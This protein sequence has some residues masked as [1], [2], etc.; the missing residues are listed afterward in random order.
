MKS[1]R[2]VVAVCLLFYQKLVY[3]NVLCWMTCPDSLTTLL[4]AS[5]ANQFFEEMIN[6]EQFFT[7]TCE[8]KEI[9]SLDK[10]VSLPIHTCTRA[11]NFGLFSLYS[12]T[13]S[14]KS[15]KNVCGTTY[16]KILGWLGYVEFL[17]CLFKNCLLYLLVSAKIMN[18]FG[19]FTFV[20]IVYFKMD[21]L[22]LH[23]V[24]LWFG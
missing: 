20:C 16:A 8:K 15:H 9:W 12:I 11:Q 5:E 22:S 24:K 18:L 3:W 4:S 2:I 10:D 14:F 21:L 7:E 23:Q 13:Y 17:Y 1:T 6:K 19:N